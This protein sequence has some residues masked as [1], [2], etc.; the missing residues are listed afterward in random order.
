MSAL[1]YAAAGLPVLPLHSPTGSGCSCRN[2]GCGSR[3]GKHPRT[4]HGLD[5]ASTDP[6]LIRA[7]WRRWPA[8][9]IGLRTGFAADVADVDD[10][11]GV[12][13]LRPLLAEL[14]GAV[15]LVRTGSGGWHLYL[16]ATGAGNHGKGP[17]FLPGVDWRGR[18]GYV[19]APPSL[20]T[21]GER[22]A[23]IRPLT[24]PVPPV[25]A[26]LRALVVCEPARF[27]PATA[28]ETP[29][30][31][32]PGDYVRAALAR[33]A[34]A[35]ASCPPGRRGGQGRNHRLNTA[36]F[37]LGQLVGAG[38]LDESEV[39][40]ELAEAA[41]RAGLPEPETVRTIASGLKAGKARPRDLNNIRRAS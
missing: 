35:V 37:N 8:A 25:P 22:Y 6:E 12:T 32:P 38:V 27:R 2:A 17:N 7:W 18:R 3:T 13:A 16:A 10:E 23:W 41:T 1:E 28:P 29:L 9:N 5:D 20:H 11:S 39:I 19:V 15:P 4:R 24:L 33:E 26:R 40:S 21:S 31:V 30:A 14:S 36:A 34:Q